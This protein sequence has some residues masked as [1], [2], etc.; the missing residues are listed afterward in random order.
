M[1]SL[2]QRTADALG[3]KPS[4][5]LADE[6]KQRPVLRFGD[7][8]VSLHHPNDE[9]AVGITV[10]FR[11]LDL[12]VGRVSRR[13][14][15]GRAIGKGVGTVVDATAGLGN[16]ALLLAAMGLTVIAIERNPVIA[17]LLEDGLHRALQDSALAA[18]IDDRIELRLGDARAVLPAL[19]PRP[20]VV[21]IDPMFPPRRKASALAKKQIR[22][23]RE[24]VGEDLDASE[25]LTIALQVATRRVVVKRPHEA[26][27]LLGQPHHTIKSKLVRYDVYRPSVTGRHDA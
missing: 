10:D 5:G 25:L 21:Y 26:E 8:G 27:P 15:L 4:D 13:Q 23:V 6:P 9:S 20:E 2:A 11:S 22:I 16:D 1:Q 7:E 17:A 19:H 18:A 3:I 14:P 12:R 24:L